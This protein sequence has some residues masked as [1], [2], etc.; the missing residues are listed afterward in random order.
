MTNLNHSIQLLYRYLF[1][2]DHATMI[3][4]YQGRFL[5]SKA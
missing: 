4:P 2:F 1:V 3:I 5:G